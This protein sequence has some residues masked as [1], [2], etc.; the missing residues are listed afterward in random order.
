MMRPERFTEKA[1]EIL[2]SS[3]ELVQ[4]MKHTQWDVEH[5]LLAIL[6]ENSNL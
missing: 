6:E 4:N 1:Q 3:Q 5:V 2:A